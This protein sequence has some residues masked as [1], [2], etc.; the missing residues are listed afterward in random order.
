MD[1]VGVFAG[2]DDLDGA[3][4]VGAGLDVD[5]KYALEALRPRHGRAGLGG[6]FCVALLPG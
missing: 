4:A 1:D 6:G 2:G 3:L 5:V